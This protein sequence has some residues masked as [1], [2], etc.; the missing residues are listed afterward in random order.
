MGFAKAGGIRLAYREYGARS[1]RDPLILLHALGDTSSYWDGVAVELAR[2]RHAYAVDLRGHGDSDWPGT[3]SVQLMCDDLV[4][5]LDSLGLD[6]VALLG[7]SMGSMVS[8]VVAGQRPERVSHLVLEDPA[9]P[10]PR[11]PRT[12]P[13]RPDGPLSFDWACTSM[14]AQA[15]DPPP[16]WQGGLRSITA[17][18]LI[19]AGGPGSHIDQQRIADMAALIPRCELVTVPV[20]HYVHTAEPAKFTALVADFQRDL[21]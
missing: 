2:D 18:T 19:V 1:G 16:E 20:G 15:N 3:Y 9:P 17:P 11:P 12:P 13:A 21:P 6:R 7:H 14:S 5:F 10:W 8:Y 4:R